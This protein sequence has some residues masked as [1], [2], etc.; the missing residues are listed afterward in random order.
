MIADH[1]DDCDY[2]A[3]FDSQWCDDCENNEEC[4]TEN[5]WRAATPEMIAERKAKA[6]KCLE[7]SIISAHMDIQPSDSF[8]S[9]FA[10]AKKFTSDYRPKYCC[11]LATEN[12]LVST[13]AYRLVEIICPEIPA[14]LQGKCIVRIDDQGVAI[15]EE[16][17]PSKYVE[18]FNSEHF[19]DNPNIAE[20]T[21][22][23]EGA[24]RRFGTD[25]VVMLH[26]PGADIILNS[27]FIKEAQEVLGTVSKLGY[28][29]DRQP[30]ILYS[31]VGRI[32]TLPIRQRVE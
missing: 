18:C 4:I 11:V 8:M 31:D 28:T 12:T 21:T 25:E 15:V 16:V 5:H 20:M 6:Q 3:R 13:D 30:V 1:E 22:V 26:V 19:I 17:F 27:R 10:L 23:E 14:E 7:D 9:A 2:C 24:S 32:S 29:N